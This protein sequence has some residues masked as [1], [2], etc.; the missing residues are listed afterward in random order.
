M[1]TSLCFFIEVH[2]FSVGLSFFI[3]FFKGLNSRCNFPISVGFILVFAWAEPGSLLLTCD[4]NVLLSLV[5]KMIL[6][7]SPLFQSLVRFV[8]LIHQTDVAWES[9]CVYT[10]ALVKQKQRLCK[11]VFIMLF[12]SL[13]LFIF[14]VVLWWECWWPWILGFSCP[15]AA[16]PGQGWY[17]AGPLG[18]GNLPCFYFS[19]NT[20]FLEL[21]KQH[22][23]LGGRLGMEAGWALDLPQSCSWLTSSHN[24][25]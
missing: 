1:P 16:F 8:T 19:V 13:V 18:Y 22:K 9:C 14:V 7:S 6:R 3:L 15:A 21:G 24:L 10:E 11:S 12:L 5:A 20:D 4:K 23:P 2:L 17:L 25:Y